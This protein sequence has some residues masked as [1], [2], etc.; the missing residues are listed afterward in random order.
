MPRKQTRKNVAMK[1]TGIEW[2]VEKENREGSH[3]YRQPE[4]AVWSPEIYISL[5]QCL[6]CLQILGSTQIICRD[7]EHPN[8]EGTEWGSR[9]GNGRNAFAS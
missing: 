5:K 8:H 6:M 4:I 2:G 9:H 1:K 7:N 3:L